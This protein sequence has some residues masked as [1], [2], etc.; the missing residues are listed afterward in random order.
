MRNI[1][2][3]IY[4][5]IYTFDEFKEKHDIKDQAELAQRVS[6]DKRNLADKK[7]RGNEI[8]EIN[9]KASIISKQV[10]DFIRK[11]S[12]KYGY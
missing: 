7:R 12:G 5:N 9:G 11:S 1:I 4:L 6:A 3:M 10:A 2:F 8:I